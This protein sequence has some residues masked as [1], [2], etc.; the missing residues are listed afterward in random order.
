QRYRQGVTHTLPTD[1]MSAYDDYYCQFDGVTPVMEKLSEPAIVEHRV[2]REALHRSV[3]YQEF[4]RG[5]RMASGINLYLRDAGGE[6]GDIRIWRQPHRPAF[7]HEA[8][9]LLKLLQPALR[10][11]LRRCQGTSL[12]AVAAA[13][14]SETTASPV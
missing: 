7:D 10:A 9:H 11:A 3:F 2:G 5:G 6:L 4:L 14:A 8:V 13:P 1:L 12:A